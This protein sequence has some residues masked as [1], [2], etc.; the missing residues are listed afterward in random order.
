MWI[1]LTQGGYFAKFR[2][3]RYFAKYLR[4]FAGFYEISR[5]SPKFFGAK[6]Q[7]HSSAM[8]PDD[9]CQDPDTVPEVR[10]RFR[11]NPDSNPPQCLTD[12]SNLSGASSFY[13]NNQNHLENFEQCCVAEAARSRNPFGGSGVGA[14]VP[15]IQKIKHKEAV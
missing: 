10:V 14:V 11:L 12:K 15:V 7:N 8:D 4:H 6:F 3:C 5:I 9:F 2:M 13:F 1:N